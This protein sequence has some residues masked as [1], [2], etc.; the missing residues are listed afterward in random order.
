V[1][2]HPGHFYDLEHEGA[3]VLSLI[4]TTKTFVAGIQGIGEVLSAF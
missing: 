1:I 4:P 2:V 3:I